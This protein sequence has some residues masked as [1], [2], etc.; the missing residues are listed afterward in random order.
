MLTTK[1]LALL[2]SAYQPEQFSQLYLKEVLKHSLLL[3][4][5]LNVKKI[6]ALAE[7]TEHVSTKSTTKSRLS[8]RSPLP[9]LSP[10]SELTPT[11]WLLAPTLRIWTHQNSPYSKQRRRPVAGLCPPAPRAQRRVTGARMS[12]ARRGAEQ[13]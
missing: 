13:T 7:K 8:S 1:K 5:F 6:R 12:V 10:P 3:L 4:H 11:W 2:S 9:Q